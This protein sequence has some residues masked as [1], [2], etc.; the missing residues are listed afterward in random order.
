MHDFGCRRTRLVR[1][2]GRTKALH[3]VILVLLLDVSKTLACGPAWAYQWL[4]ES[5]CEPPH[6]LYGPCIDIFEL[7]EEY[8]GFSRFYPT[9][10]AEPQRQCKILSFEYN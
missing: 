5:L 7:P 6:S 4:L 9:Y 8:L 1:Q 3:L 10:H 2:I